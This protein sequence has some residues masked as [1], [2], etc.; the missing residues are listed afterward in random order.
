MRQER[1]ERHVAAGTP[2]L[3]L[4]FD[5]IFRG[6]LEFRLVIEDRL[7]HGAR[8]VDRKSDAER[9][10]R[11]QKK[12]FLHPGARMQFALRANIED[13]DGDRSGEENRNVEQEH[14]Q[15]AGLRAAGRG[16]QEDAKTGEQEVG[17]I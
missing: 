11:R 14:A 9:D 1:L 13:R 8:I 17:E 2:G 12:D 4:V 16:M 15:P 3:R 10:Q 5:A 6:A 7:E